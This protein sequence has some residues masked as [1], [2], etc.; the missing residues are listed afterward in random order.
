MLQ[1]VLNGKEVQVNAAQESWNLLEYLRREARLTSAKNGCSEGTCGACTVLV[2]GKATRACTVKLPKLQGKQV[3][4]V[5][6]LS[7]QEKEIYSWAF[8]TA[9]AVQCGFCIPGMVMSAKGLLDQ[10]L[11]PSE[12][13]IK[14]AIRFNICRCTGYRKI[15]DAILLA[16]KALRG[17][18]EPEEYKGNGGLG[19]RLIRQ[20]AAPKVLG[21]AEY[22]DDLFLPG[23]L[24]AKVLRAPKPRVLVK[25]IDTSKAKELPGVTVLTAEDVPGQNYQGYIFHDW[26]TMVPVGEETRYVGDALAIVAAPTPEEAER[27]RDLIEVDYEELEPV[28]G[29]KEALAEGAPKIHT[30]GNLLSSTSLKRGDVDEVLAQCAHVVTNNYET[31]IQEHAFLEPESALAVPEGDGITVY[32]GTQ[33]VHHDRQTLALVLGMPEEKI[34]VINKFVGGGFGGKEDLSVQHHAALLALATGKPVKLTL[35]REESLKVHP[36]RHPMIMELTTGCDEEGKLLAMK[37]EIYFDTGA[38]ASL[39]APVLQRACTH[40]TGPYS[41]PNID[42]VGYGC[43]TNNPP[44]GAFRGFGVTQSNFAMESQMDILADLVGISPWEIRFRNA[45][46]PGDKLA[47][48]QTVGEDVGIV[49]TLLAVKE[50]CEQNP[51]AGIACAMKNVGLGVGNPDTGRSV[52]AVENG[53]VKV[54]TGAACIGQG[55]AVVLQQV[56]CETLGIDHELIDVI[57]ADTALTPDSGSTTA[58]RQ[59]LFTGEAVRRAAAQ[60][61]EDLKTHSLAELEGKRYEGEYLGATDPLNAPVDEPKTHVSYGYA[62]QVCILDEEGRV[63][64]IVAA[65]DV[66]RVINPTTLEGQLQGGI[67]MAMGLALTENYVVENGEVKTTKFGRLGLMR[68]TDMPEFELILIEPRKSSL[69]YGIKGVGEIASIPGASAIANAYAKFDGKRRFSLPLADT[70][71]RKK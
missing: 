44:A 32:V 52:V 35:T 53:R 43:Y 31:P 15:V 63:K 14:K 66:G 28:T 7:E 61:A 40:A 57:L 56:A 45:L 12:E 30:K 9:G 58:S 69:A 11:N 20:D 29:P 3:V 38:Y 2:D 19:E 34:R 62:T 60:L 22:V 48:G 39:G 67:V 68:A 70:P 41:I 18:V 1:F 50:I 51:K 42:I 55:L 8:A 59:S 24:Y 36:K 27:A 46:R 65:H 49:E 71:Y 37:A 25:N 13:E 16:A 26:P 23:M 33:S 47:T 64:K 5:E 54:Y 17:E 10:N 4:T 6:G 21:T